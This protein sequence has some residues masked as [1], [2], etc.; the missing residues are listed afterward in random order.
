MSELDTS[1][2]IARTP[3]MD[4]NTTGMDEGNAASY[5]LIYNNENNK[6]PICHCLG[7]YYK[8]LVA[9]SGLAVTFRSGVWARKTFQ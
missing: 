2:V 8:V 9:L 3:Q 4:R 5:L 1:A 7:L 6:A